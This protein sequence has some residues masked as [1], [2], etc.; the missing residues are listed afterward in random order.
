MRMT[1]YAVLAVSLLVCAAAPAS[2]QAITSYEVTVATQA[3]QGTVIKTLSAAAINVSCVTGRAPTAS[4]TWLLP[5]DSFKVLFEP[6]TTRVCTW[7]GP[8]ASTL[9]LTTGT[10]YVAKV[11]A[12]NEAGQ[13]GDASPASNPFGVAGKPATILTVVVQAGS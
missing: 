3:A 4:T 1:L 13:K 12:V 6:D 7:N 11:A 9:G 2:A 10:L 8:V 5:T